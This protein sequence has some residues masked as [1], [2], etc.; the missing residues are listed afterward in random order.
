MNTVLEFL[1]KWGMLIVVFLLLAL[2]F[3]G[4]T[5][6]VKAKK[7]T[8]RVEAIDSALN[9]IIIPDVLDEK[10]TKDIMQE[11]MFDFIIIEEELDR[12]Q[13]TISEVKDRIEND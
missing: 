9:A 2:N 3:K 6:R 5:D 13:I 7:L 11:V 10:E 8:D 1:K 12:K 4:C